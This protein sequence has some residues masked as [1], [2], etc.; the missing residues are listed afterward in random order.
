[1]QYSVII[2]QLKHF[3]RCM[4]VGHQSS[5]ILVLLLLLDLRI[6]VVV[7]ATASSMHCCHTGPAQAINNDSC[8]VAVKFAKMRQNSR[9]QGIDDCVTI[10]QV[11]VCVNLRPFVKLMVVKTT[12]Q[13][14]RSPTL[15]NKSPMRPSALN[16]VHRG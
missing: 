1:M 16:N 11:C 3:G 7:T 6:T 8:D 13:S 4:E 9:C 5:V 15:S 2:L 14:R 10:D 12:P